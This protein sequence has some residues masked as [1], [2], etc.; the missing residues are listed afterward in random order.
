MDKVRLTNHIK[1]EDL[2]VKIYR[3]ID[4]CNSVLKNHSIRATEFLNPF[5]VKNAIAVLNTEPDLIYKLEGGYSQ[6][7][8]QIMLIGQYYV[9]FEGETALRYF[10][11][12]GNFKFKSV[13][14]RDYLGSILGLGIKREKLGDILVHDDFCQ[15]IVSQDMGDYILYNLER[16]GKNTVSVKEIKFDDIVP[17]E[18]SFDVKSVSVSSLRLDNLIAGVFNLS[19]QEASKYINADYVTVNYER[20]N[21]P[22][23]QIDANT[24]ISVRKCGKFILDEVGSVSKKGKIRLKV[25]IYK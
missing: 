25:S 19:R 11:I 14:H 22:S 17:I 16:V 13:S 12:R 6:A 18:D 9:D 23:R 21:N 20:V 4:T 7:T 2:R 24:V 10:E 1:D 8:R 5:E 15:I 3:I